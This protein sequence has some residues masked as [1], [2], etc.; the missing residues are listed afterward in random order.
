MPRNYLNLRVKQKDIP[1]ILHALRSTLSTLPVD[2]A[3]HNTFSDL[4][5]AVYDAGYREQSIVPLHRWTAIRKS[6]GHH[7]E[8]HGYSRYRH[9]RNDDGGASVPPETTA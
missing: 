9:D 8:S 4:L 2:S 6:W 1:S 7:S 5:E 3:L